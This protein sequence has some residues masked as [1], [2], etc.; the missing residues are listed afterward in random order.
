MR[1]PAIN[2]SRIQAIDIVRGITI[3][4]VVMGH[5]E[6]PLQLNSIFASFR[7]PLFF[8]VSGYLLNITKHSNNFGHFVKSRIWRLL[9]PYFSAC[10]AFYFIWLL[11]QNI[12]TSDNISLYEPILG[13][14]YG[15]GEQLYVNV[16]LWFLVCL[17]CSEIIFLA[18][19]KYMQNYNIVIQIV[20][21]ILLGIT[22]FSISQYFHLP[23]GL[24]IALAVQLF[25]F[26]GN[27][28]KYYGLFQRFHFSFTTLFIS[29]ILFLVITPI[30]GFIDINNRM[31]G[32]I[33]LFYINGISGSILV[34]YLSQ[35]IEN[36]QPFSR[37][38]IYLGKNSI[39]ILMFH[40]SAFWLL[41]FINTTTPYPLFSHWIIYTVFGI[42]ISLL[43]S[44]FIKKYP[45]TKM[46]FNGVRQ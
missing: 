35:L 38:F 11:R 31:Y 3:S 41:I 27:K 14:L 43:I 32:N 4:L 42:S 18:T 13:I 5:T 2:N 33:I 9:I 12:G 30:N 44:Y 34:L 29:L 17:F 39:N 22:G 26:I 20:F 24:D 8:M 1:N 15:N 37:L 10:I 28:F 6:I 16:P 7:M 21:Y 36:K 23:W 45:L 25:L 46:L 19:M 40:I